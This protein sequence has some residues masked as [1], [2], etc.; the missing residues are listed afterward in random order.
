MVHGR[1]SRP[2]CKQK[3]MSCGT[4]SRIP[5][6]PTPRAIRNCWYRFAVVE[7]DCLDVQF[8]ISRWLQVAFL[9]LVSLGLLA[10]L[11]TAASWA[12]KFGS[13]LLL[14]LASISVHAWSVHHSQAGAIHLLSDGTALL[15]TVS[16]QEI[17]AVQGRHSWVSRWICVVTLYVV[18]NNTKHHCVICASENHPDEYRRLLKLLRMRTAPDEAHRMI[19]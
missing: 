8:G 17:N 5:R 6:T 10:I 7:A 14:I 13:I 4:G 2:C 3:T 16:G 18:D 19:W 15:R 9:L 12:W 11:I 1:I